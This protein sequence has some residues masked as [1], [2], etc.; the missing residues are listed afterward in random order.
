MFAC[1]SDL[2]VCIDCMCVWFCGWFD[3]CLVVFDYCI[4]GLLLLWM[5]CLRVVVVFWWDCVW[6]LRKSF[7][8]C[9][10]GELCWFGIVWVY[11]IVVCLLAVCRYC[12]LVGNYV[13]CLLLMIAILF[14]GCVVC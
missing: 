12:W 11:L 1:L 4:V 10:F 7:G 14:D 9:W 6:W 3:F 13:C 5:M 8:I 2:V